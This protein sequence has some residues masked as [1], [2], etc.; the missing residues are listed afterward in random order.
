MK[1]VVAVNGSPRMEKGDTETLLAP[2]VRGMRDAG[3]EVETVYASRLDVKPCDCGH[4]LCWY[5]HPGRCHHEDD[6]ADLCV[7]LKDAEILVLATPVYIPLPGDMQDVVNRLCPLLDPRLETREGRTRARFRDDVRIRQIVLVSTSGW[8]EKENFG[9]VVRIVEELARDASVEFVG[10]V[11]RPHAGT[12][13]Q[14]GTLT[15]EAED[16]LRA[17]Q[18]AGWELIRDG[19]MDAATLDAVSRPLISLERWYDEEL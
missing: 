13:K 12:M 14:E 17:A 16:V 11:L 19:R 6:M 4:M 1:R 8:W 3:A 7:R 15:E 5:R 10:A 9:T 18:Q 2:F